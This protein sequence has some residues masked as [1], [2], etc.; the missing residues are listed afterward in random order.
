MT[1]ITEKSVVSIGLLI[2][3]LGVAFQYSADHKQIQFNSAAIA[4]ID[5][6]L[7]AIVEMKTDI[8]VIKSRVEKMDGRSKWTRNAVKSVRNS[9]QQFAGPLAMRK[10][11]VCQSFNPGPYSMMDR[12]R[13]MR[14]E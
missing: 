11:D 12:G 14:R 5:A 1:K 6:N 13:F 4:K 2:T 9:I 8:A 3:L 7:A 10:R